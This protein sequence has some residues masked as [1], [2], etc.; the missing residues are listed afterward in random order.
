MV[1]LGFLLVTF[2]MMT[3]QFAPNDIVQIAIPSST[4]DI[5][6]PESNTATILISKEGGVYYRMDGTRNLKT[7]GEQLNAK[8]ALGLTE[9]EINKFSAQTGFGVPIGGLKEFLGLSS[10][11]QKNTIQPGIP[12]EIGQNELADWLI[13]GRISNTKARIVVKADRETPYYPT[14]KRVLDILR[15]C[16][17][18]RFSLI[19][20]LEE[21][22]TT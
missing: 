3:T 22:A 13:Y 16:E 1:D 6:L 5:K 19:T 7:L 14:I 17:I 8:Y 9:E 4:A 15:D 20:D 11:E 10:A 2:F 12:I 18:Y 21:T